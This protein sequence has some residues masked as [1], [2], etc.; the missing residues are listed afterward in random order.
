MDSEEQSTSECSKHFADDSIELAELPREDRG[1][2]GVKP[3]RMTISS[4]LRNPKP[5]EVKGIKIYSQQEVDTAVGY[6]KQRREFWNQE[7]KNLSRSTN[8]SR[9]HIAKC[10]NERWRKEKATILQNEL[11]AKLASGVHQA[12][13]NTKKTVCKNWERVKE[14]RDEITDVEENM[15]RM[16]K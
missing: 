10:I 14:L 6:E 12:T 13:P 2:V 5:W 9:E 11:D 8:L 3:S 7:A 16:E 15:S 1:H 4:F